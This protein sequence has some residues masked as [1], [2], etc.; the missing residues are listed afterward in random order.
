MIFNRTV[1]KTKFQNS[2]RKNEDIKRI[3]EL[4]NSAIED[5]MNGHFKEFIRKDYIINNE[6]LIQGLIEEGVISNKKET[7]EVLEEFFWNHTFQRC[8]N[9]RV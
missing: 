7:A 4:I 2:R 6:N 1:Q 8:Q 3:D 9:H 5:I